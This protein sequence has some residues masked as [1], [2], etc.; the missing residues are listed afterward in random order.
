MHQQVQV[1]SRIEERS[2][3]LLQPTTRSAS[4]SPFG[5]TGARK[6]IPSVWTPQ[7]AALLSSPISKSLLRSFAERPAPSSSRHDI[8]QQLVLEIYRSAD[9]PLMRRGWVVGRLTGEAKR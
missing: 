1:S 9:S 7:V 8:S 3:I 4:S 5:D 2:K 6:D